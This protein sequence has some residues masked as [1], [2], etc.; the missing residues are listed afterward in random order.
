M[1]NRRDFI[2][3]SALVSLSP[4]L[5]TFLS[6]AALAATERKE[7]NGRILV[8]IQ[9]D[10]G[11]DGINTVVPFNDEGYA[12]HRKELRLAAKDL[13]KLTDDYAFHPR[14][15]SASELFE[16]GRLSVVHG[17]GYPNPNRSHFESMA[18]W[19]AGSTEKELR[20]IGNGWIGDAISMGQLTSGPHAIHV[21]HEALP[22]ALQGRRCTA[23][24]ISNSADLQLR[25]DLADPLAP[26]KGSATSNA[27]LSDFLTKSVSDAYVSAKELASATP[28]EATARYPNS[29]LAMRLKLVGQMIKSGAAARVYYTLQSG[30]DTHA[31]Q[32]A[33]HANLLGE[34]S[35]SLRA[36]MDD[37]KESRL[38][39]RVVVM[40][41]SEFGRRVKENASFGTDHGTAGPVFLAGTKLTQRSYGQLPQLT[42]LDGGDLRY[43]ID[44]RN[45]YSAMLSDWLGF[46]SPTSMKGFKSLQ[47]FDAVA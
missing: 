41:F 34:L 5:P 3:A 35:S 21:G 26:M 45:V 13:I 22:V 10:G 40:A 6:K 46:G 7:D 32:L 20:H 25:L 42:D 38:D 31:A 1:Q 33:S 19:H 44:F 23:T 17:V 4:A 43:T 11:N 36:F 15:R 18:I 39:D 12:E 30:Y 8:V 2:K 28:S 14:L 24:T 37:L 47:L 16:D 9:L 27:S 29:R